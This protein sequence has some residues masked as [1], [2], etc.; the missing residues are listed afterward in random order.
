MF[1]KNHYK[2][3]VARVAGLIIGLFVVY[4]SFELGMDGRF[5]FKGSLYSS[6]ETPI[7]FWLQVI[8]LFLIGAY[9]VVYPFIPEYKGKLN[10]EN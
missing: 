8:G 6:Q 7:L 2:F 4:F 5:T 10:G 9:L 3:G 1:S